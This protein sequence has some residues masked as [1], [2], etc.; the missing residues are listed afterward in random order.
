MT[1]DDVDRSNKDS[2][3]DSRT[4]ELARAGPTLAVL[5]SYFRGDNTNF[6]A[7]DYLHKYGSG[8]QAL[9]AARLFVPE[10]VELSGSVLLLASVATA[11]AKHRFLS[12]APVS[13]AERRSAE[14]SFNLL[15]VAY[16]FGPCGR[17]ISDED[18]EVLAGLIVEAWRRSLV[19]L[20]PD[21]RFHVHVV[22]RE[23]L[24]GD[25][26]VTFSELRHPIDDPSTD[27]ADRPA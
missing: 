26:G 6:D 20:Y 2:T 18:D 15:E 4:R 11:E 21:R 25:I 8:S 1:A 5:E 12:T 27:L 16:I 14:E 13:D 22:P 7:L 17:D 23:E 10:F 24:G 19:A 3:E 9:L